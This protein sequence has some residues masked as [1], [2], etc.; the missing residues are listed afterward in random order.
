MTNRNRHDP[1][2]SLGGN[3]A[4]AYAQ[5]NFRDRPV[6]SKAVPCP[7][8]GAVVNEPCVSST[9]GRGIHGSRRRMALRALNEDY[10]VADCE[11]ATNLGPRM[12]KLIREAMNLSQAALS[13]QIG[14][15]RLRVRHWEEERVV[16]TGPEGAR[17]GIWLRE[18][19]AEA[20][21]RMEEIRRKIAE[22]LEN[23]ADG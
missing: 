19:K 18:T 6:R 15:D 17:Y 13:A 22:E 14:M 8:C 10:K 23:A 5:V 12:R 11:Y 21:A 9:G 3:K 16:I 20:E 4:G 7:T 2:S 1:A